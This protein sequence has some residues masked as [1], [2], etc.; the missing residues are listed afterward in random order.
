MNAA[1]D[2]DDLAGRHLHHAQPAET[3]LVASERHPLPVG[4]HRERPLPGRPRRFGMFERLVDERLVVV[5]EVEPTGVVAD[6]DAGTVGHVLHLLHRTRPAELVAHLAVERDPLDARRVPRHVGDVPGL[7][8]QRRPA[9]GDEGIEHEV[10]RTVVEP[11]G[12]LRAVEPPAPHLGLVDDGD[13]ERAVTADGRRFDSAVGPD[14][15]DPTRH[16][17]RDRLQPQVAV[18]GGVDE[19]TPVG[20]PVEATASE[21]AAR[22]RLR[23]DGDDPFRATACRHHHDRRRGLP[24]NDERHQ[25]GRRATVA[26]LTTHVPRGTCRP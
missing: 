11:L 19:A 22:R 8:H 18:T 6:A 2:L 24:A 4:R 26:A 14:A 21:P 10:G 7:P 17:T 1:A 25:R 9:R 16:S 12:W 3:V 5:P 13:D 23:C 15:R 20:A